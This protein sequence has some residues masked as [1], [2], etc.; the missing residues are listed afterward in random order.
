MEESTAVVDASDSGRLP[1]GSVPLFVYDHGLG[2]NNRQ[3]AFAIRD[4]S[5]HTGVV[6][7]LANSNGYHVTTHGWV[8]LVAPGPSPQTRL[9][10]PRSGESVPLPAMDHKPPANWMCYLS[11]VPTAPSLIVLVLNMDKPNFLYL[12][13]RGQSLVGARTRKLGV[14]DFSSTTRPELSY[15]GDYPRVEYPYESNRCMEF[16]V[17]SQGEIFNVNVFC[18]GFD[19]AR[20]LKVE[21][22]RLDMSGPTLTLRKVDDLG[23]RVF[24]LSYPNR[25]ALCSASKYGLK[26]NRVYFNYNVTGD[27]DGGP[28]CIYDLDDQSFDIL[29]PCTGMTE[30]M[31]KPFWMLPTD[32]QTWEDPERE[33]VEEETIFGRSW[34]YL[35]KLELQRCLV[36]CTQGA[37][38]F[39]MSSS[40]VSSRDVMATKCSCQMLY[41]VHF[42]NTKLFCKRH[43]YH[44]RSD[45]RFLYNIE[46]C[47]FSLTA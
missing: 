10:D 45:V 23:D 32:P 33:I 46:M 40:D 2:T 1:L 9:W 27:L 20:I 12:P 42:I 24:L 31:G 22:Y 14:I 37:L 39:C 18:K 26:G 13:R 47:R 41:I 35:E 43:T 6:P 8:L 3:T 34:S 36:V 5:L 38:Y 44:G 30:L 4:G 15:V 28:I 21:V 19:P 7:E 11:D 17:E 25:Q 29:W 16:L